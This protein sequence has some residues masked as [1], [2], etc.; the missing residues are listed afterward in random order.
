[1]QRGGEG[2][3]RKWGAGVVFKVPKLPGKEESDLSMAGPVESTAR[4]DPCHRAG[5]DVSEL[6]SLPNPR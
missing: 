4:L 1:M 3:D 5:E 6:Y 2:E